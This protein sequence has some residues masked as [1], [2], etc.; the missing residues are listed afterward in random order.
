MFKDRTE[1]QDTVL[2]LDDLALVAE[3]LTFDAS[4]A[5]V[6]ALKS[7]GK[8]DL[9]PNGDVREG[10][11]NYLNRVENVAEGD[12]ERRRAILAHVPRLMPRLV[13]GPSRRPALSLSEA[14]RRTVAAGLL[15]G[16]ALPDFSAL[17]ELLLLTEEHHLFQRFLYRGVRDHA[18][19]LA[20]LLADELEAA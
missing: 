1:V 5:T 3:Y 20:Q 9:I 2:F 6:E 7:T 10:L 4:T 12:V 13:T 14:D 15:R 8:L 17:R 16:P 18:Q 19:E 11:L